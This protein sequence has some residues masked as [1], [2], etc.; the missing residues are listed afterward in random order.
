VED[1][2]ATTTPDFVDPF[3][4]RRKIKSEAKESEE[5]KKCFE[6]TPLSKADAPVEDTTT[7]LDRITPGQKVEST[8][9]RHKFF[10]ISPLEI[11]QNVI[12]EASKDLGLSVRELM[13]EYAKVDL[14]RAL[15]EFWEGQ[16]E[17]LIGIFCW[18]I[19]DKV[20][21]DLHQ[22]L[23]SAGLLPRGNS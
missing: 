11:D 8:P 1:L 3:R 13:V 19:R 7:P 22:V 9:A 14:Q 16:S 18:N 20:L 23:L 4:R 10:T 2:P 21:R 6:E 17:R 12:R 5:K 15:L